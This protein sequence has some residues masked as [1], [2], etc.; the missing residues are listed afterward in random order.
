MF[1]PINCIKSLKHQDEN[2]FDVIN[3]LCWNVAKLTLKKS[4][5]EYLKSIIEE[6]HI[7]MLLLQEVKK[8]V[9]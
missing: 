1:K 8:T 9:N 3:V 6:E 5:K 4:Y 7:D 2:C